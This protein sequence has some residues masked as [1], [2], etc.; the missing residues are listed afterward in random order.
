MFV[1]SPES[2]NIDDNRN[3]NSAINFEVR[4]EYLFVSNPLKFI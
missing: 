1:Q 2:D 3:D 4:I